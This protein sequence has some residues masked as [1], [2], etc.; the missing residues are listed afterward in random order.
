MG[1]QLTQSGGTTTSFGNTPQAKD[2][3]FRLSEDGLNTA[4]SSYSALTRTLTLDVM[5][6]DLGGNAKSLFSIDDA[7]GNPISDLARTDLLSNTKF[8]N[9]EHT[10][11]GNW[12]RINN[13]KVEFRLGDP[14]HPGDFNFARDINSLG[15]SETVSDQFTYAIKLGNGTLSWATV[16]IDIAGANDA[17]TITGTAG[18]AVVEAGGVANA[19]AGIVT[20]GGTLTVHDVDS[21]EAVFQPAANINGT[22]G[23]FAFDATTGVWS[24]TLDNTRGATQA[25]T[26]GQLVSDSLT[27]T[28]ADGTASQVIT[29]QITGANDNATITGTAG[30]A[31]VE[32]GGVANADAGTA[33]AGGTLVV[34]DVDAGQAGFQDPGS[35]EGTYGTFTFDTGSGQWTYALDN[36]R[37]ATQAL[38]DGQVVH[39][40]LQIHSTDGTGAVTIDVTITGANDAPVISAASD[41]SGAV[42]EGDDGSAMSDSGQMAATDVDA[43]ATQSWSVSAA[44]A[45]GSASIDASGA[46]TYQVEDSGAVDAL[47]E[48][49]TLVDHFTVQVDD[50]H[51]GIAS[52]VVSVTI[53]G[54]ND[55]PDLFEGAGDAVSAT[56]AETDAGLTADGTLSVVDVDTLDTVT[57]TVTGVVA[58]GDKADVIGES[59]LQAMMSVTAGAIAADSGDHGNLAWTFNSGTEAFDFLGVGQSLTLNYTI[60]VSDGHGGTDQ[61]NVSVTING[62]NDAPIG[63]ADAALA[64]GTEDTSY[65]IAAADLLQ[66]F[67]DVDGDT[68]QATALNVDHGS[69]VDNDD[70]TFT[71]TPADNYNGPIHLTYTVSDGHGGTVAGAQTFALA[72]VDDLHAQDDSFSTDEDTLLQGTVAGND[73]TTSGGSLSFALATDAAHGSLTFNADGTFS[74]N[75]TG[76]YFG[77]DSFTYTVTDAAANESATR[78]VSLTVDPVNDAA[79]ISGDS[80]GAI[81]EDAAPG[82]VGG[83][84]DSTDVD[85]AND[86]WN[87]V[88][89][90]TASNLG[91]GTFTI[92]AAGQWV[93]TLD[94][95]NPVVNALPAGAPLSDSFTV[96]TIDGTAQVVTIAITG[97]NDQAFISGTKTG[98]VTE[99]GG[100]GNAVAGSP[101][102]GGQ[103]TIT[104]PDS[105]QAAFATPASLNGTYGTFT[106]NDA[107]GAWTYALDN[108]RAA[109]EA[110]T[111][112]QIVTDVLAI[113]SLDGTASSQATVT[114]TGANDA[115]VITGL[116]DGTVTEA[117][118]ASAGMPSATGDLNSTDVDGTA[119]AW[120]VIAA[121]IA[122]ASGYG[123]YSID[124]TGHWTYTLNNAN[125]VVDG[126]NT[127]AT[128]ND[129]FTVTT[130]DGTA[131]VVNVL[132][133]GATDV[134]GITLPAT[135]IGAGD[136]N[137]FDSLVNVSG[138]GTIT[139][140]NG[141]DII[142]AGAGGQTING[143]NGNDTI[144]AGS[145][146]D[147]AKGNGD[148]DNLYGGSGNDILEGGQGNDLLV[149][150]YGADTLTGGQGADT[151]RYLDARDTNDTITDFN[152]A[153]DGFNFAGFD[154][155]SSAAGSQV[156]VY[157]G[158]T[159]T[160]HGLWHQVV[161]SDTVIYVDTDGNLGTA[162]F[163]LTLSNFTGTLDATDF[164]FV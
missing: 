2:D 9:W 22:Y 114:V 83:N 144:Y 70:G 45:H 155:D 120:T 128:L 162:E 145:G 136:P 84:L 77:S 117:T 108:G 50:G 33:T 96:T 106:F 130:A 127:G 29:V 57:A 73:S 11:D 105:G 37:D 97:A 101:D 60:E 103:F 71:F 42:S 48:G 74:Y 72:A 64:A 151:F 109:T 78:T 132:I 163:M 125:P 87:A 12:I 52:Q 44:A 59:A 18:G 102:T 100:V 150:G 164:Q 153:D 126:L 69:L 41:T 140:T 3:W 68:L 158:T 85:N 63:S 92:D 30:G 129:S 43:G 79:V 98:S 32:A 53:T 56:R 156:L 91:Y 8:S 35:L 115:A 90:A 159:P 81:T 111:A 17:A 13:G 51:G 15:G 142:Y 31:V 138:P 38:Y 27:V 123:S 116:H 118:S 124:A 14:A 93:Y 25:L 65:V 36:A 46:W 134:V 110:L 23:T 26:Q 141:N 75:P 19:D 49:Q 5:A 148:G 54:T 1:T 62:T 7:E 89:T 76:N 161:G 24:Y 143:G 34:H 104:D 88:T 66:G 55:G 16:H 82:T 137:D 4:T 107:T 154:A 21:G 139:G 28:S 131:Q 160:A 39:D 152:H 67:S 80:S 6:N 135:Y 99:A 133:N 119:D 94:N 47:A 40:T 112:G 10:D 146:N 122:T 58:S 157:G 61:Q 95:A 147:S 113:S 121:P 149:G 20:A 86:S